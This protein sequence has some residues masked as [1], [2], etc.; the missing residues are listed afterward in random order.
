M[1]STGLESFPPH[2]AII[3]VFYAGMQNLDVRES[4]D[5]EASCT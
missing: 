5:K 3:A 1:R 4:D 2:G